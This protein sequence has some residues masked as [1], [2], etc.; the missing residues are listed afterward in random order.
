MAHLSLIG[1]LRLPLCLPWRLSAPDKSIIGTLNQIFPLPPIPV[2]TSQCF[3]SLSCPPSLSLSTPRSDHPF[4]SQ[5]VRLRVLWI[6]DGSWMPDDPI[7][8]PL[9]IHV[10]LVEKTPGLLHAHPSNLLYLQTPD[11]VWRSSRIFSFQETMKRAAVADS[12]EKINQNE[13]TKFP[14]A[15]RETRT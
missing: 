5:A 15:S 12:S 7:M 10:Y 3:L 1:I 2:A 9:K 6:L 14:N 13:A 8:R 4:C 11:G